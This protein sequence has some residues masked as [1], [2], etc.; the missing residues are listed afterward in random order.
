MAQGES[1]RLVPAILQELCERIRQRRLIIMFGKSVVNC[2]SFVT[3]RP[4]EITTWKKQVPPT[5]LIWERQPVLIN[6]LE[7][8]CFL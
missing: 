5:F 1:C 8:E 2:G 3:G 4:M 7:I 6:V